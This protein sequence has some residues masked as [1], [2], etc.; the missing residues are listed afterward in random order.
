[1]EKNKKSFIKGAAIL[2]I[3]GLIVKIIGAFYRIPL[4]NI[5]QRGEFDGMIYYATAYPYYSWLLVISSAGFPT[6]ISKLVSERVAL[7]DRKGA[8]AVFKTAF[9]LLLIIGI[10][11]TVLL[12]A[13]SKLIA[14]LADVE[15]SEYAIMALAP[16]LLVVSVMCAYR[17]YLQ[18]LQMMTG[19]ALSQITEQVG[20]LI[21]SYSLA[22]LFVKLYPG[23]PELWAMGTLIG[24]SI[25]EVLGL[26]VIW[27]VYRRNRRKL[28]SYKLEDMVVPKKSLQRIGR[29][30]L[31]I[32][33]PIT[34]GASI[35]P[36]TGIADTIF[37]KRLLLQRYTALGYEAALADTMAGDGF[38]ALRSYVTPLIN[39]PAV[40]TLALSMSLVPAIAPMMAAR[41]RRGV[42]K[43]GA[44]GV[45]LAMLIGAPCA[46]GLFVLGGP[47]MAMLYNKVGQSVGP[48]GKYLI[49]GF[50]GQ[51]LNMRPGQDISIYTLAGGIMQISA[52]G[53]LFLSLVQ[54][55][56]GVIQGMGKQRV[57]VYFLIAGGALKVVSMIVLMKFT[58]LGVLGAAVSTVLCY[59]VAGIGDTWYTL[60]H[61]GIRLNWF[62]TFGKPLLSALVMGVAVYFA[63]GLV[64]RMGHPTAAT[65]GSVA[66]GV[67][68]YC[69]C[70]FVLRAFNKDDLSFMPASK[71]LAR[72]FRVK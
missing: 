49:S 63:Y 65:L 19:T 60:T 67:I 71:K 58:Q 28:P 51:I 21:A 33:I 39:M 59:V 72:L 32:A 46:A 13:G 56:T 6:A 34:I 53:V 48:E 69:A 45:K 23:R 10:V 20:K 18:G 68:V 54:T 11:T 24:I 62:D 50:I 8:T 31:A 25:S 47:I 4:T 26:A 61:A 29:S 36:I 27:L 40:L 5:L 15:K 1:M 52:I 38:V 3:A 37:I 57:P 64:Y 43:V 66:V 42:R 70:L 17:G 16:S 22:L 41:D 30:L 2:G 9:R 7:G 35:M 55:L 44:T 14:G 12:F